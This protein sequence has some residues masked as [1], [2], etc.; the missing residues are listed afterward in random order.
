MG[1][2][3]VRVVDDRLR[4]VVAVQLGGVLPGEATDPFGGQ[5]APETLYPPT[6]TDACAQVLT[7]LGADPALRDELA[8]R[9]RARYEAEFTI[10][11]HVDRLEALYRTLVTR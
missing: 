10:A 1:S 7:R 5:V 3:R 4:D 8:A 11:T 2:V 6:D 9:A